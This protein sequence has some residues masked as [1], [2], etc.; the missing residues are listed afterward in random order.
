MP[1]LREKPKEGK[2]RFKPRTTEGILASIQQKDKNHKEMIKEKKPQTKQLNFS[3]YKMYL[4]IIVDLLE[5]RKEIAKKKKKKN[6][7]A[8]WKWISEVIYFK[9]KAKA[10]KP[11][12]LPINSRAVNQSEDNA[13][14]L[15]D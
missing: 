4:N 10:W 11:N 12:C 5:K 7:E 14:Y 15:S 3:L 8:I 9:S 1:I 6:C 13:E 2:I